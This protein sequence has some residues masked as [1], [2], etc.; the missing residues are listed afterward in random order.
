M[1]VESTPGAP[2]SFGYFAS[3]RPAC[4]ERRF[5]LT[6]GELS[7]SLCGIDGQVHQRLASRFGPFAREAP[8]VT[9]SVELTR[10]S[11]LDYFIVPRA[12]ENNPILLACDGDRVRTMGYCSAG[13]FDTRGGEGQLVLSPGT[14]EIPER[15]IE[16]YLRSAVAWL[17]VERGGALVH[18]ASAVNE[19]RGYLFYGA[20]GAGKSTLSAHNRRALIVSDD[21]SL[22]L[23]GDDGRLRLIGTPFRG[24][25]EEGPPFL[26][27]A[28]LAAGFRIVKD[29]QAEVR[30]VARV[31]AMSELIGNLPFVAESFATRPDL[32]QR[33]EEAF[34]DVPLAHLHFRK[35]DDY[36]D[37]IAAA[38]Y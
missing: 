36:W 5:S 22:V 23:P 11:A 30:S 2:R 15:S 31:R 7:I 29:D 33:V 21:L 17:A 18:A 19:D 13:W 28:P 37:A 12:G 9:L 34:R 38:G 3:E 26:G 8:E 25:Y 6:V 27:E 35:D 16:N 4:G 14:H 1:S 10:E 32:F 24:T 20:S